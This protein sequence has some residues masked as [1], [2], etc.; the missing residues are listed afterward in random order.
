MKAFKVGRPSDSHLM[1]CDG[2]SSMSSRRQAFPRMS[3][4]YS[5]MDSTYD[6]SGMKSTIRI[7]WIRRGRHSCRSI[8]R[9]ENQRDTAILACARFCKSRRRF[10]EDLCRSGRAKS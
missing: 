9:E 3:K 8:R 2:R 10:P 1:T 4:G 7:I 5:M 6:H